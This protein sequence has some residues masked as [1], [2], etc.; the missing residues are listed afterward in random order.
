M[1]NDVRYAVRVLLKNPAFTAVALLV[2]ALGIG[3]NTAIFSV[4]N[5]LVLKPLPFRDPASLVVVWERNIPRDR[6]TNVVAP[7]NYLRWRDQQQVFEDM[8]AFTPAL[9][10]NLTGAGEPEE[11]EVQLVTAGLIPLLGVQPQHGRSFTLA[12][13]IRDGDVVVLSHRLWLRRFGAD[14]A[15]VGKAITLNGRARTVAGVMPSGFSLFDREVELWAPLG[16]TDADRAPRGRYMVAL[17]RLK[18]G[19]MIDQAQANMD[20]IAARLTQELPEFD[21][22]WVSNVVLMQEQLVGP[23]RP[24][25]LVLLGAVGFVLLIACANVANL[26]LVRASARQRELALRTVLGAG[27]GRLVRQLFV[28]SL[29]LAGFGGAAGL[30]LAHF[31]LRALIAASTD[32]LSVPRIDEI[33]VDARVLGFAVLVS[34]LTGLIFGAAP[35]L[36]A[37]AVDLGESL[38]EGTRGTGTRGGRLRS[39]LVVAEIALALML[40]VGA[41]LLIRS[42]SRLLTVDPGF[43]PEGVLTMQLNLPNTTYDS[44]VRIVGFYRELVERIERLPGVVSAGGVSF[45]PLTGAGAATN[46]TIVGQPEPQAGQKPVADVRVVTGDYFAAMGIPLLKGRTFTGREAGNAARVVVINETMA[47]RYWPNED[48]IGQRVVISWNENLEDEIVGVVGDSR[49]AGLDTE[50]RPMTYWPNTRFAYGRMALTIRTA[51]DPGSLTSAV[52]NTVRELDPAQPVSNIRTMEDVVAS[53]VTL[54]R[55]TMMLLGVFALVALTLAAVGI[56][57]VLAHTVSQRTHEIGVRLALGARASDVLWLVVGHAMALAG[58]GLALGF[59]GAYALTGVMRA[60]LFDVTPTD[61]VTFASV[62]AVLGVV[63]LTASAIPALRA[64]RTDPVVALRYE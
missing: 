42:F 64:V 9:T 63:A 59:A 36:T 12:E 21:T 8:A 38:K 3:A 56:Y 10:A 37:S 58:A 14:P 35:A 46:F 24:A 34:I 57:G 61:P 19:V 43:R 18:P 22:G 16:L 32:T 28:E 13:D 17:A 29:V 26:L 49:H 30:A 54:R 27:R 23:V 44:H 20:T 52:V 48:P 6:K 25:L 45:L 33:G 55:L 41:G 11:I 50:P 47:R 60:L 31:G 51:V 4:V 15:I 62:A 5:T 7:A 53:S 40:L 2:L 39:G 1:L